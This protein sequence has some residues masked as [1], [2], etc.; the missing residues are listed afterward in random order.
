MSPLASSTDSEVLELMKRTKV[1]NLNMLMEHI[2]A[3][4]YLTPAELQEANPVKM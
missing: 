2:E 4:Q 1:I 3:K